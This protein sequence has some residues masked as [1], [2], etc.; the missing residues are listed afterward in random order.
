MD[1]A[2]A[3]ARLARARA[4]RAAGRYAEAE[5]ELGDALRL[6]AAGSIERAEVA[7]AL[8]GLLAEVGHPDDAEA[9][10]RLAIGILER[11]RGRRY[12]GL[13]EPLLALGAVRQRRGDLAAAERLYRRA[14]AV[15]EVP[16]G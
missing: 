1:A 3:R 11:A 4:S 7:T 10:L 14:I 5:N 6:T 15:G 9:A 16:H 2:A 8:G 13:A 12:H